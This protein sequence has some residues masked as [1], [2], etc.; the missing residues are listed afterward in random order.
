[1]STNVH[2]IKPGRGLGQIKFGMSTAQVKDI[3]GEPD[4]V[5][6]YAYESEEGE[7]SETW[8]YD[9][10]E[11]SLSFDEEENWRLVS[12]A[13]SSPEATIKGQRL[14]GL[15]R[16]DLIKRLETLELGPLNFED[17]S[18][19]ESPDHKLISADEVEVNFWLDEEELSEIQF[20]PLFDDED[21]IQWP[22]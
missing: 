15:N 2:E 9:N 11:L 4:E 5:E 22:E 13:L 3:I 20:G 8:H 14:I 6:T 7:L 21:N 16:N 18:S 1:M 19:A 17:W 10:L 12:I